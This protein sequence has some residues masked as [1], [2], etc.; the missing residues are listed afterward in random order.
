LGLPETL[1]IDRANRSFFAELDI[2]ALFQGQSPFIDPLADDP[3]KVRAYAAAPGSLGQRLFAYRKSL[4]D[5]PG[6]TELSRRLGHHDNY[7]GEREMNKI[8]IDASNWRDWYDLFTRTGLPLDPLRPFLGPEGIPEQSA[9]VIFHEA[10]RGETLGGF[11]ARTGFDKKGLSLILGSNARGILPETIL[12][13]Q[14]ALP[15]L[16]GDLFF[17]ALRPE[18]VSFFPEAAA[19]P[20]LLNISREQVAEAMALNLGEALYQHRMAH[21]IDLA[22]MAERLGVSDNTLKNYES[23]SVRIDNP[24]VLRRAARI[25]ELDPRVVYLQYYPQVLRLFPLNPKPMDAAE[26]RYWTLERAG[27]RDGG[28]LREKLYAAARAEGIQGPEA[29]AER[30]S[31]PS[32]LAKK[33]WQKIHPLTVEEIRRLS[34]SF[35]GLSYREWYEHFQGHALAYF[36]G[37]RVDGGIDYSLP[38]GWNYQNIASWDLKGELRR[39]IA[40]CYDSPRAAAEQIGVGFLARNENLNRS[41]KDMSWTNDT[42][43]RVARGLGLDRRLIFLYFRAEELRPIL[44]PASSD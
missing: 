40:E 1:L 7:W 29:L 6:V 31:I 32:G 18:L 44:Y 24:E 13:L 22:Q 12:D 11:V 33:Y 3:R 10:L 8:P 38:E 28:N 39:A 35:P 2:D 26:Y 30:M 27:M 34:D 14:G 4:S 23:I 41:L 9:S 16:K 43:A 15:G 19:N 17:R 37:R 21:G 36:L 5:R 42:I 20:P 25:L